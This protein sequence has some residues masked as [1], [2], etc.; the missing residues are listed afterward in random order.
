[1]RYETKADLSQILRET[2][3]ERA[4][5][6]YL[7]AYQSAWDNYQEEEGGDLGQEAYAHLRGMNAVEMAYTKVNHVWYPK[8]E[9]PEKDK[10]EEEN[11]LD[12]VK[13]MF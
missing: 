10:E 1:M 11:L 7:E 4:Q 13:D 12:K 5:D 8:E 6:L 9:E 3:P 2:L